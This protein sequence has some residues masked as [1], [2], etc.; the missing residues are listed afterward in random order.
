MIWNFTDTSELKMK[1]FNNEELSSYLTKIETKT[2]LAYGVYQIE[3][4]GLM[5]IG[6]LFMGMAQTI[7][8]ELQR[9]MPRYWWMYLVSFVSLIMIVFLIFI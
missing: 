1:N 9:Q 4:D 7:Q 5:W 6:L 2:L 3:A 8:K